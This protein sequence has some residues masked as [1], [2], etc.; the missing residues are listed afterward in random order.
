MSGEA[1]R[2]CSKPQGG[3][4]DTPE[5][6]CIHRVAGSN[7]ATGSVREAPE[8]VHGVMNNGRRVAKNR[9]RGVAGG[10]IAQP[11]LSLQQ[12]CACI[13]YVCLCVH[14]RARVCVICV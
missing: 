5:V 9:W 10:G 13:Q 12:V 7:L 2:K 1:A 14:V 11:Q 8:H 4:E 3:R 6:K